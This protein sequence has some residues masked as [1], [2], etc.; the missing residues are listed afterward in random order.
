MA[1]CAPGIGQAITSSYHGVYRPPESSTPPHTIISRPVQTPLWLS[2]ADG[3]E[4]NDVAAQASETGSYRP[5]EFMFEEAD[6]PQTIA[7]FPVQTMGCSI[8]PAGAPVKEV[9]AQVSLTGSYRPPVL[10]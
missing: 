5:P 1:G 9:E 6:P 2:L 7:S 4:E 3:A 8:L 10:T